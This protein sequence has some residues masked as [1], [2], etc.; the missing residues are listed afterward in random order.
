MEYDIYRHLDNCRTAYNV[1]EKKADK[2]AEL[3]KGCRWAM[4]GC[5][6]EHF[7]SRH[8]GLLIEIDKE[9]KKYQEE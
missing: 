5:Y 6:K 3:L 2:L 8:K 4:D 7:D 1:L 9:L